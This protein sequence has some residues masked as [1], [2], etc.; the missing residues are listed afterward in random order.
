MSATSTLLDE[1]I[2]TQGHGYRLNA[3]R[4]AIIADARTSPSGC[5]K[6]DDAMERYAVEIASIEADEAARLCDAKADDMDRRMH[7]A[8]TSTLDA[9][10]LPKDITAWALSTAIVMLRGW[11]GQL[12]D[13]VNLE[14]AAA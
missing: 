9:D 13:Y 10:A 8:A 2:E 4:A 6:I 14:R 1:L 12:R 3:L 11:A 7:R 5:R